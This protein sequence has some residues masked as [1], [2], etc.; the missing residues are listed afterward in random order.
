MPDSASLLAACACR[1][2]SDSCSDGQSETSELLSV[3]LTR[4]RGAPVGTLIGDPWLRGPGDPEAGFPLLPLVR[5]GL[6]AAACWGSLVGFFAAADLMLLFAVAGFSFKPVMLRLELRFGWAKGTEGDCLV[7]LGDFGAMAGGFVERECRSLRK[8]LA[9]EGA[10][11]SLF[12]SNWWFCG[13]VSLPEPLELSIIHRH[14]LQEGDEGNNQSTAPRKISAD[15]RHQKNRQ[16]P[17]S[18]SGWRCA[19]CVM[20]KGFTPS[21]F[22]RL[23]L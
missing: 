15:M 4:P 9:G 3:W 23:S 8:G 6:L 13:L 21:A 11:F 7:S 18:L 5:T 12:F 16:L 2:S 22:T 19:S 10:R 20:L 14:R 17:S 1:C